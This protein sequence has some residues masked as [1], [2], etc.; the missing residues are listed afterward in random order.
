MDKS[1]MR[2]HEARSDIYLGAE[3]RVTIATLTIR[4]FAWQ[5]FSLHNPIAIVTLH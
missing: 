4:L 1:S 3:I 2:M 5:T